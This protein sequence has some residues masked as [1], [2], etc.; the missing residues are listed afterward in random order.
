MPQIKTT[1]Y[2]GAIHIAGAGVLDLSGVGPIYANKTLINGAQAKGVTTLTVD[3]TS[4]ATNFSVGD[5]LLDAQTNKA[6]GTIKSIDSSTQIT[7][8]NPSH[9][10]LPDNSLLR[11]WM[12]FE[13]VVIQGLLASNLEELIPVDM[14]WPG[15][16]DP[17]GTAYTVP[18]S[19]FGTITGVDGTA[20]TGGVIFAAGLAIE[21]RWQYVET[22]AS[23]SIICYLKSAPSQTF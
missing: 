22:S 3:G 2:D 14:K 20:V 16:L 9:I 4:P 17:D 15:T 23:D 5:K 6:I 12:P 11:K 8:Q 1:L 7:L 18:H 21:G 13:I 10:A 19:S